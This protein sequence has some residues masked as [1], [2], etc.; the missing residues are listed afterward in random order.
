MSTAGRAYPDHPILAVSTAVIRDGRVLLVRRASAPMEGLFTLPGGGVETGETLLEAAVREVREETG[1]V[2]SMPAFVG[3]REVILR[4]PEGRVSA[5]YVIMATAARWL[6]GEF[7]LNEELVEGRWVALEELERLPTTDGLAGI[8]MAA[9][10]RLAA[11][12]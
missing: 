4:D 11:T 1:M 3:Y 9:F 2:T 10:R 5:H 12:P 7:E 8:V 6:A